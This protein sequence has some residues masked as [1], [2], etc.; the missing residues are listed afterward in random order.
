MLHT[1]AVKFSATVLQTLLFF[2]IC[3]SRIYTRRDCS[4][5]ILCTLKA[6][7]HTALVKENQ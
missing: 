1:V 7:T 2:K 4:H 3:S 5:H 6:D